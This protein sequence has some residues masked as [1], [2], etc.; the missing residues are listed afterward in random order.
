MKKQE[1]ISLLEVKSISRAL[2]R[3]V[4]LHWRTDNIVVF[5]L[6]FILAESWARLI[7]SSDFTFYED[8]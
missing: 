6:N 4:Q 7:Y 3:K 8:K 5:Y 1:R 2:L